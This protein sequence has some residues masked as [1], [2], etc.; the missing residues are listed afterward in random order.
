MAVRIEAEVEGKASLTKK[1]YFFSRA[2]FKKLG[3]FCPPP[4]AL[5]LLVFGLSWLLGFLRGPLQITMGDDNRLDQLYLATGEGGFYQ[6]E[7]R[8]TTEA[9]GRKSKV[10]YRWAGRTSYINLPWPTEAVPLKATLRVSAPR[11][12]RAP[13]KGGTTLKVSGVFEWDELKLGQFDLTGL[14]EGSDYVFKI[15]VHLRPNLAALALRFEASDL[16]PFAASRDPRGL[17]VIFFS[18]KLEPDYAELGWRGWLATLAR[19]GLLAIITF[20]IW[21][22]ANLILRQNRLALLL[23][24]GA[25]LLLLLSML[26]WSLEAEPLYAPWAFILPLGWL[27]VGLAV[28]FSRR[29]EHLPAPFVFAA[30]LFPLVPL[31]QF[32]FGRLNLYSVNPSSVIIGL[33]FCALLVS[34]AYYIG[35][36]AARFEQ[37]FE[38]VMLF[39]AL[40]SFGYTH[41]STW[42]IDL[43]RGSDFRLYYQFA[44]ADF[45]Q[46]AEAVSPL[47]SVLL[48]PFQRLFR[49]DAW[50]ALGLWRGLNEV[51]LV[52]SLLLLVR[53]FGGVRQ[54]RHY[55]PAVLFLGLN[56]G[57]AAENIGLGQSGIFVLLGLALTAWGLKEGQFGKAGAALALVVSL[58]IYVVLAV[59]S[60]LGQKRRSVQAIIGLLVG[61][62]TL[63]MLAVLTGGWNIIASYFSKLALEYATPSVLISNQSWEGFV[64]RLSLPEVGRDYKGDIPIWA[65]GLVYAGILAITAFTLFTVWRTRQL[66]PKLA[67]SSEQLR[68]AVLILL[69]LIIPPS[70]WLYATLPALIAVMAVLVGLSSDKVQRWQLVLFGLAYAILAYGSRFDFFQDSAVGLARLGS[71]YR[72]LA[73]LLLWTLTLHLL[74]LTTEARRNTEKLSD[75]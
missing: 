26:F 72:F 57:Q 13:D 43:Y 75:E 44:P 36:N 9:D 62:A 60:L 74:W 28:L 52:V 3:R 7:S 41:F 21:G 54:G 15:P 40:V 37:A 69:S 42:Q 5:A 50:A 68:F 14:Y 11:P 59:F 31:A 55:T 38:M 73:M 12:E 18:L 22:I 4:L 67:G 6:P 19:P 56:F 63:T 23:Q 47:M 58:K 70:V 30:T 8:L 2:N 45:G 25:G 20:C 64:Y 10:T 1:P 46:L 61:L 27:L 35:A 24:A 49:A 17:S 34:G 66:E 48:W 65:G 39:A 53:V 51:L 16:Y 71:S 29:A 32:A 33:Y